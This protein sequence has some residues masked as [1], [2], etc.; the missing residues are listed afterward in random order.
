M[1][2]HTF[3]NDYVAC[4]IC[5]KNAKQRVAESHIG[6]FSCPYCHQRLVVCPSG[7]YVRD[8][9]MLRQIMLCSSLRRQSSPLARIIRDFILI[10]RP[11]LNL[12][13]GLA[14]LFSMIPITQQNTNYD[15]EFPM[16]KNIHK[17]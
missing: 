12:V 10:K 5:Q 17:G 14:I 4:P 1:N 15:Q 11:I 9:Y 7:H 6:L 3:G 8:P 2:I 13:V 16:T